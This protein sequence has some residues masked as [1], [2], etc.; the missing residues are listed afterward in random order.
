M[1]E[2]PRQL[3]ELIGRFDQHIKGYQSHLDNETQVRRKFIDP[4]FGVLKKP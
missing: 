1:A 3:E 2:I 4:F